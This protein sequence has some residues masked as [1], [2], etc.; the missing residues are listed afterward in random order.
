M[1][2]PTSGNFS[3][4]R[5]TSIFENWRQVLSPKPSA[6]PSVIGPS[7]T[8]QELA[9][10]HSN[11]LSN[12]SGDGSPVAISSASIING[13]NESALMSSVSSAWFTVFC[14]S[15]AETV[16]S[17]EASSSEPPSSAASSDVASSVSAAA[18]SSEPPVVSSDPPQ[19][20]SNTTANTATAPI[21]RVTLSHPLC[22]SNFPLNDI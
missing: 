2:F 10:Q 8:V 22:R 11:A 15:S 4:C 16:V 14:S 20:A 18:V 1:I 13:G 17:P 5:I 3:A 19:P 21:K 7:P 9:F 12:S 6:K